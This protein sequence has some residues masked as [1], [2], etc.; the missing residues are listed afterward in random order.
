[1]HTVI[2]NPCAGAVKIHLDIATELVTYVAIA[3][4]KRVLVR[5]LI[6]AS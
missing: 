3:I 4:E 6:V 1:M 5:N 2:Y